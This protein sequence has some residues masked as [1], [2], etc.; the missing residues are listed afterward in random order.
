MNH[1]L[2]MAIVL[3]TLAPQS[4]N[5]PEEFYRIPKQLRE[6]ATVIVTG[7][8]GQGR[9]PCE[10]RADGTRVWYLDSWFNVKK[11]YRGELKTKS[12]RVNTAML[13]ASQ[14]VD[15]DLEREQNYLILLRPDKEAMKAIKTSEGIIF[16]DSLHDE[17]IIAIVELK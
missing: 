6:R 3:M 1:L 9:T 10:F 11:V 7:T 2:S 17:E 8:F 15:K 16:R 14:Y 12:I 4:Q 5:L 13:P